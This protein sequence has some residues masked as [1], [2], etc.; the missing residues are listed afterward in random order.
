MSAFRGL[1]VAEHW[2]KSQ[3]DEAG[4]KKVNHIMDAEFIRDA[5]AQPVVAAGGRKLPPKPWWWG[6]DKEVETQ[7]QL[8]MMSL[9]RG[10]KRR[11]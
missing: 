1:N 6:N 11:R 4:V 10:N 8:A 9:R 7:G 3:L 2:I 5:P